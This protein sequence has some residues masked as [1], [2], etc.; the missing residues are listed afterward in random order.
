APTRW[1]A[2]PTTAV[3]MARSA[4][5]SDP[6][7][8]GTPGEPSS[9]IGG[10]A[11]WGR[12]FPDPPPAPAPPQAPAAGERKAD[13]VVFD[14][15]RHRRDHR[16]V[17]ANAARGGRKSHR[18]GARRLADLAPPGFHGTSDPDAPGRAAA[19]VRRSGLRPADGGG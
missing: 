9:G 7:R 6:A 17:R 16:P 1:A 12:S 18:T 13:A 19:A 11:G 10:A 8:R 4:E 2:G 15:P 14:Q 3:R 5:R